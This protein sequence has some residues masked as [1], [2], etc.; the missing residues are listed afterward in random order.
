MFN[1]R[2]CDGI[3]VV[4]GG[5]SHR[6]VAA[7]GKYA[8]IAVKE[9]ESA[10]SDGTF[11]V[12]GLLIGGDNGKIYKVIRNAVIRG[13]SV[14][15][16]TAHVERQLVDWYFSKKKEEEE[17]KFFASACRQDDNNHVPR[18]VRDVLRSHSLRRIQRNPHFPRCSSGDK[19]QRAWGLYYSARRSCT[20]SQRNVFCLWS[21]RG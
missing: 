20:K 12:G 14:R 4:P 11:G 21:D 3:Y 8:E 9:A 2:F 5:S 6:L 15:D 17:D 18:S 10:K 19:L 16:P 7:A 13:N 1:A